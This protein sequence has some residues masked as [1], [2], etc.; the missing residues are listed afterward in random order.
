MKTELKKNFKKKLHLICGTDDLR[1]ALQYVAFEDGYQVCT[2]AHILVK[3]SLELDDFLPTEIKQMNGKFLH[4]DV[5]KEILRYDFV[6]IVDEKIHCVKGEIKAVFEFST[7]ESKFPN[8]KAAIPND[9]IIECDEI[10][11]SAKI[12]K[13]VHSVSSN[14]QTRFKFYGKNKAILVRGSETTW[15]E[16]TILIMPIM[17]G[18]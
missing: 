17:L 15:D 18:E 13:L 8:W 6:S 7:L 12:L 3:R 14:D 4:K 5:Y 10:G 9:S 1:Q 11:M 16:E 2:D